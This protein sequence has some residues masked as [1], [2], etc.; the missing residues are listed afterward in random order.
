MSTY[1]D[2]KAQIAKLEKQA[3]E[4]FKKEVAGVIE[5]VK[6]L[7]KEYCLTAADL[8]FAEAPTVRRKAVAKTVGVAKYRDPVTSKTWTGHGPTPRFIVEGVKA[9]KTRDDFLIE[10]LAPAPAKKVAKVGKKPTV[11]KPRA[12]KKPA[13]PV[14]VQAAAERSEDLPATDTAEATAG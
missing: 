11:K 4:L 3:A 9:G 2:V 13:K 1:S 10:K 14:V 7:V 5:Q 12:A 8:G 6:A